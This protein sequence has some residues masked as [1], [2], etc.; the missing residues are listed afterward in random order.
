MGSVDIIEQ[1]E[2]NKLH[3]RANNIMSSGQ[4][5][6]PVDR[7]SPLWGAAVVMFNKEDVPQ[8][9]GEKGVAKIG[10]G[11]REERVSENGHFC[12]IFSAKR[13]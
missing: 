12:V 7:Q 6:L 11:D 1:I 3:H 5:Y 4:P 9:S 10:H 2:V 13:P 8:S